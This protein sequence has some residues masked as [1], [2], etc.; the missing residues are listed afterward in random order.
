M[1]DIVLRHGRCRVSQSG[2]LL[3]SHSWFR[4]YPQRQ[5]LVACCQSCSSC[6][7]NKLLGYYSANRCKSW[8]RIALPAIIA[9]MSMKR[10]GV[11]SYASRVRPRKQ[12]KLGSNLPT[13]SETKP[14]RATRTQ[15]GCVG[16]LMIAQAGGLWRVTKVTRRSQNVVQTM[17]VMIT[18]SQDI[19]RRKLLNACRTAR[20]SVAGDRHSSVESCDSLSACNVYHE[21]RQCSQYSTFGQCLVHIG[22]IRSIFRRTDLGIR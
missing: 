12:P 2:K 1:V 5:S 4:R 18:L 6:Q 21:F 14:H 19:F 11:D 22:P 3:F 16:G 10:V 13:G 20:H 17:V 15:I 8:S 9:P 7:V